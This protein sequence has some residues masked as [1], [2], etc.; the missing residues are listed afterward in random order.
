MKNIKLSTLG[1][2]VCH[3]CR[4]DACCHGNQNSH[5]EWQNIGLYINTYI[6]YTKEVYG[7]Y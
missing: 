6:M 3:H 7:S 4:K 2:R 5:A 1:L